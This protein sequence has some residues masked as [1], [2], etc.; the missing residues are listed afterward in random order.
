ML[1]VGIPGIIGTHVSRTGKGSPAP[2]RIHKTHHISIHQDIIFTS[3]EDL[4]GL[5][6]KVLDECRKLWG[7]CERAAQWFGNVATHSLLAL[8]LTTSYACLCGLAVAML[9]QHRGHNACVHPDVNVSYVC[10]IARAMN[11]R[12]SIGMM[13]V[14]VIFHIL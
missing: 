4:K 7:E 10:Y 13:Y 8:S 5:F 12:S 3:I 2:A 1:S 9:Q 14:S 11:L 6:V